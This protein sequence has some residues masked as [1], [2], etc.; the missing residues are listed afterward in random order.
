M[1]GITVQAL[2]P[3]LWPFAS[4]LYSSA[5]GRAFTRRGISL[6]P[7]FYHQIFFLALADAQFSA[8]GKVAR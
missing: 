2:S 6:I 3:R 8:A 4:I 5:L 7:Y 1:K